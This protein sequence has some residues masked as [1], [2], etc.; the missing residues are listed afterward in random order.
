MKYSRSSSISKITLNLE[1]TRPNEMLVLCLENVSLR[2]FATERLLIAGTIL[3]PYH[4]K[5]NIVVVNGGLK[6]RRIPQ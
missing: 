1:I 5:H 6:L 3:H 2:F 4:E